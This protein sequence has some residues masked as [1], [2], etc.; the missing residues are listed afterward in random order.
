MTTRSE[1]LPQLPPLHVHREGTGPALVA[2]PGIGSTWEEFRSLLPLLA[3]RYDV[4]ALDLPGQGDSPPLPPG[5]TS[6]V[7]GLT[8]AVEA[9]LDQRGVALPHVLGVSLGGRV[10]LEL[11]RR[12]RARSVVAIGPTGPVTPP[13]RGFQAALLG[14]SRLVY[15]AASPVADRLAQPA[16]VRTLALFPLR[17]R[18]WRA[19]P[20]E[21]AALVRAMGRGDDFWRQLRWA[22]L[23][24]G[25]LDYRA[26]RCPVRIAQGSADVLSL[27]QALRL[28][29]LVPGARFS[30][31]PFAGH[32]SVGDVPEQVAAL[33]DDA[34]AAADEPPVQ[35]AQ[36]APGEPDAAG[37]S[38]ERP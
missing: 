22:I 25:Q 5:R 14:L 36:Q 30:W 11:A 10:A 19:S 7:A 16:A 4:L 12:G 18:G 28:A 20:E 27:G 31:L 21:A 26:V 38:G 32:S 33:V 3:R 9:E 15:G 37:V 17:A 34:A 23:P 13:E 29:A 6:D 35:Q 24:E 8:D 1:P 2:L